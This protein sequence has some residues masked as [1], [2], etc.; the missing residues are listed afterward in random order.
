MPTARGSRVVFERAWRRDL[1]RAAAMSRLVA[2][3]RRLHG[4]EIFLK[5]LE[6]AH[7]YRDRPPL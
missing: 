2:V 4:Q 1:A 5:R 3:K 6:T 7:R